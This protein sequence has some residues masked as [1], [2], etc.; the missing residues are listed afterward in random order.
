M[1]MRAPP[2]PGPSILPSGVLAGDVVLNADQES[3]GRLEQIMIDVAS[4]RIAYA[5]MSCGGV[6]GIGAK[7]Y[8][9]AWESLTHDAER[10]C[11]FLTQLPAEI[12]QAAHVS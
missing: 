1:R 2:S 6:F 9:I 7:R 4:G 8:A 3:L 12:L 5:V 10:H 11:F